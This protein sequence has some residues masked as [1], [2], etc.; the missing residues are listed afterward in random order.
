MRGEAKTLVIAE[1]VP[2]MVQGPAVM[3]SNLLSTFP[4][5]SYCILTKRIVWRGKIDESTR[6]K[7]DESTRLQCNYYFLDSLSASYKTKFRSL[8]SQLMEQ[9]RILK[10][11][12]KALQV[13][14]REH[15]D[16][17]LV[18]SNEGDLLILSYLLN[19]VT[20]LPLYVYMLDVYE[21]MVR[22][23]VRKIMASLFEEKILKA[24]TKVFVM[25]ENLQEHY[26]KKYNLQTEF[27]P[28][29]VILSRYEGRLCRDGIDGYKRVVYTGNVWTPQLD[30]LVDMCKAVDSLEGIKFLVY[31]DRSEEELREKGICGR[32]VVVRFARHSEIPGIQRSADILYLPLAFDTPF[33][34]MIKT[35]SPGKM[36]EYLAAGRPI[37]VY[38]PAYSYVSEHARKH[39]FGLVVNERSVEELRKGLMT[40]LNKTEVAQACISN[41]RSLSKTHDANIVSERLISFLGMSP[42]MGTAK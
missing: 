31:N 22:L 7:L 37:L 42:E 21:E 35:A 18:F 32:N 39:G 33:P 41:A 16:R 29:P 36:P 5:D 11:L 30:S 3:L 27:I 40:L 34:L 8:F 28:H 23:R 38:A 6:F 25:S 17:L 12:F 14:K 1:T 10:F 2:P 19:K 15:A 26:Q 24:A 4:K 13:I 20:N 9:L